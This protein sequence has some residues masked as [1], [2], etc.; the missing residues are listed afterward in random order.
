MKSFLTSLFFVVIACSQASSQIVQKGS[1]TIQIGY[2]FPSAMQIVGSV[3]KFALTTEDAEASTEFKYKGLGPFHLRYDKMLGGRV[4]LG[5]S[6]NAEFGNFKF[7]A[8]YSDEDD[9]YVTSVTNFNYSS[10]NALARLNIHFIKN[11][12]KID[13]YY[14]F[15]VG[16]SYTR[17]KLEET[18]TGSVIDPEDQ[19]YIDDFNDY[20]NSVFKAFPIAL[21]DVFG[22]KIPF[23]HNAGMYMEVGYS[24]ALLQLGFYAK[25][26]G[27]KGYDSD[28]WKWY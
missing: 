23:N 10:I 25:L 27:P 17:V 4:G 8:N 2:G 16:Y 13:I 26:G 21:E 9:N 3:F 6:A 5:L 28:D 1:S 7:T 20:L 15:G 14:G 11:P 22:M 12:K 18:L 19:V 24:K